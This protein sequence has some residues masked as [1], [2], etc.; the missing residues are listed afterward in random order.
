LEGEP[1]ENEFNKT[2]RLV[3]D[4][5]LMP[6]SVLGREARFNVSFLWEPYPASRTLCQAFK[7]DYGLT[8]GVNIKVKAS[9]LRKESI[10]FNELYATGTRA[11]TLLNLINKK[12]P[13]DLYAR[14]QFTELDVDH[15][16]A[17]FFGETKYVSDD[18]VY[19]PNEIYVPPQGKSILL[20]SKAA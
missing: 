12:E 13:V 5:I 15:V 1:T 2:S 16:K 17:V 9:K 6:K 20:F 8:I 3:E 14:L 11:N 10:P 4:F 18:D 19:D 7:L